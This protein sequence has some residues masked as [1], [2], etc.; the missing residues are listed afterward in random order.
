VM[1]GDARVRLSLN[2][3]ESRSTATGRFV[4]YAGAGVHH[5]ALATSD[6]RRT[7]LRLRMNGARTLPIPPNYYDD[8]AARWGMDE[9]EVT[10]LRDLD[11][12]YDRDDAGE[13]RHAYT[14]GFKEGAFDERFFF[15]MVE[16]HGYQGFGAANAGMRIAAQAQQR[17]VQ[18]EVYY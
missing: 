13:F 9:A 16:R 5:I 6:L 7:V 2:V 3:S 10:A 15:E 4:A 18:P 8:L 14:G 1:S 12:L 11:L 17:G